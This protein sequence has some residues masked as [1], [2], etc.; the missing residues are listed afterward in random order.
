M[1][2]AC[3]SGARDGSTNTGGA[4]SVRLS[5]DQRVYALMRKYKVALCV[6][7]VHGSESGRIVV[8]RFVYARFH[9]GTQ[10]TNHESRIMNH[11]S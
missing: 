11:E 5:S 6:H 9:Y 2:A 1:K 3:A 8:G 10:I 7:D 4:T